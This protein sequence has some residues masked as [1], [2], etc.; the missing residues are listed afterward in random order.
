MTNLLTESTTITIVNKVLD[1]IKENIGDYH[2]INEQVEKLNI[3]SEQIHLN[4]ND[5]EQSKSL[6]I[7]NLLDKNIL[8]SNTD[9]HK[10]NTSS[11]STIDSNELLTSHILMNKQI[12]LIH[13]LENQWSFWYLKNQ[14]GKD[15]Q[16]NLMKLATFSYVEEFW[17]LFNHL[18]VASRLPPSCDYMLFKTPILPCWEDSHNSNGGRWV[19]YF[20]KSEQVYLNLD[21]CWLA[22][23][24]ALIGG[25]YAQDTNYVNGVVLSA[26]KSC[27]RIALW[28]SIH[29]DQQLIFR[30][31]RRMRELINIPR[32]IHIL[33]ELHNQEISTTTNITYKKKSTAGNKVLYQL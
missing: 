33:F 3:N 21:V 14:Q 11:L 16:D 12:E 4:I 20:S 2:Q 8:L 29:H 22:S 13:P 9:D 31:G 1:D 23:M 25:Q 6:N 28:T 17:A 27:D 15:W 24:L 5:G 32:Q 7:Q 30:I 18:R 10:E 19:L 26:R